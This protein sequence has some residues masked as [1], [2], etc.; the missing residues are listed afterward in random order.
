MVF[1]PELVAGVAIASLLMV[2]SVFAL[3]VTIG[4]VNIIFS[5]YFF[6]HSPRPHRKEEGEQEEDHI[7]PYRVAD[8]RAR[9]HVS[10]DHLTLMIEFTLT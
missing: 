7:V 5:L 1:S 9:L 4:L 6:C 2:M 10:R 3:T 8:R